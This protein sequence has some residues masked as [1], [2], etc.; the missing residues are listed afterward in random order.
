MTKKDYIVIAKSIKYS[1][2]GIRDTKI[3][4]TILAVADNIAISLK[5][6]N[7]KFSEKKWAEYIMFKYSEDRN[8][9]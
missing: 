4:G 6:D 5:E 2:V 7:P 8:I 9:Q 1:M 3:I